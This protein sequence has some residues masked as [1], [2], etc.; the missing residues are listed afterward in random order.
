MKKLTPKN[1]ISHHDSFIEKC[2][3]ISNSQEEFIALASDEISDLAIDFYNKIGEIFGGLDLNISVTREGDVNC[4]FDATIISPINSIPIEIKSPRECLE[5][6]IKAIRQAFENKIVILSRGFFPTTAETT[7]L[8]I[9]FAYPPSRSDVYELIK[10]IKQA[11]SVNVGI[12][13]VADLLYIVY[14]HKV[15]NRV[16]DTEYMFNFSGKFNRE[17]AFHKND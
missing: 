12:I 7:S 5:I 2:L 16:L 17:K 1:K 14:E 13:S 11:F 15:N 3:K 4:R 10:D 8:A 6:N 9:A